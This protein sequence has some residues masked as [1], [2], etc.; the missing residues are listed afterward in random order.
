M[1]QI[2]AIVLVV[3]LLA[4]LPAPKRGCQCYV[5]NRWIA[6]PCGKLGQTTCQIAS[7]RR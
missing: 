1:K 4:P 5:G 3:F 6:W 7:N 2:F